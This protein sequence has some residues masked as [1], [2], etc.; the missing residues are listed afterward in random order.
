VNGILPGSAGLLSL[1]PG[2]RQELN[3]GGV[4]IFVGE[5]VTP[6]QAQA[7]GQ[8][9]IEGMLRGLVRERERLG[10]VN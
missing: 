3:L 5:N 6:A 2:L 4:Q 8:D 7:T 10:M 1:T 9:V